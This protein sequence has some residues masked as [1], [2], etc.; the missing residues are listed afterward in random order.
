MSFK[1]QIVTALANLMPDFW[2]SQLHNPIFI[3]GT[4]RSGT[5]LL[6][7]LLGS[8]PDIANWSEANVIWDPTGYPYC[9]LV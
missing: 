5:T 9:Q 2:I 4:A 1:R 6:V 3:I 8:H 7:R